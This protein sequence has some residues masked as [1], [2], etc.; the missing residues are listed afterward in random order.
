MVA[1]YGMNFISDRTQ[2]YARFNANAREPD[3]RGAV[4]SSTGAVDVRFA[5][6]PVRVGVDGDEHIGGSEVLVGEPSKGHLQPLAVLG[7]GWGN[8]V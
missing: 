5:L 2:L 7:Q 1:T 3:C 8:I 6:G 4:G